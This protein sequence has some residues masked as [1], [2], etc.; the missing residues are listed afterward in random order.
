V[1]DDGGLV[2]VHST[3]TNV[4]ARKWLAQMKAT[5][6]G[7]AAAAA[8]TELG[9]AA[10]APPAPPRRDYGHFD[11]LSLLEPHKVLRC[12]FLVLLPKFPFPSFVCSHPLP[13]VSCAQRRLSLVSAP[14]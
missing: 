7:A 4:A 8:T 13:S 2:L 5:Q 1:R 12:C 10:D 14:A 3:L 6:G 11:I 9:W